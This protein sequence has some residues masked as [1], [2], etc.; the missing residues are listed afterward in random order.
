MTSHY[1][2]E[3]PPRT[4]EL[5][6]SISSLPGNI[7]A[8]RLGDKHLLAYIHRS[9]VIVTTLSDKGAVSHNVVYASLSSTGASCVD[10][11]QVK[12]CSLGGKHFLVLAGVLG[13]QFF[14]EHGAI[15]HKHAT[16]PAVHGQKGVL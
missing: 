7:T 16:L 8:L 9:T 14:D 11:M 4:V 15:K 10:V 6:V 5:K 12:W 2:T 13:V 3:E 1:R